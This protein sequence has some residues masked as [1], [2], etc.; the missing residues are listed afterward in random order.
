MHGEVKKKS[1][2]EAKEEARGEGNEVRRKEE[3][4]VI[5]GK[6][7]K[8]IKQIIYMWKKENQIRGCGLIC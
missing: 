1:S 2:S 5:K 3:R 6:G 4:K 7:N 8:E